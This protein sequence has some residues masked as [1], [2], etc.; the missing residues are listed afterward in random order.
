VISCNSLLIISLPTTFGRGWQGSGGVCPNCAMLSSHWTL[1]GSRGLRMEWIY[2]C[3]L[4][5]GCW[6]CATANCM[7]IVTEVQQRFL[8]WIV[9]ELWLTATCVFIIPWF[10]SFSIFN[11]IF[12]SRDVFLCHRSRGMHLCS[13]VAGNHGISS[14]P[15][16]AARWLAFGLNLHV[17]EHNPGLDL[18]P[19][20]YKQVT[21]AKMAKWNQLKSPKSALSTEKNPF[22][23]QNQTLK[24]YGVY[25]SPTKQ[26]SSAL[27]PK[28]IFTNLVSL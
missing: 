22:S 5:V 19:A 6:W 28:S 15:T 17:L 11:S 14:L 2:I 16:T 27:R 4:H 24:S 25:I 8:F 13:G 21:K 7:F 18:P 23:A 10:S 3:K 9:S 26:A 20:S 1:V 12:R